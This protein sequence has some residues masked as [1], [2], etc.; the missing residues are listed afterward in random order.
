MSQPNEDR[1]KGDRRKPARR[2]VHPIIYVGLGSVLALTFCW[3]Y[4]ESNFQLVERRSV[5]QELSSGAPRRS[6]KDYDK[7]RQKVLAR[8]LE[9]RNKL[10]AKRESRRSNVGSV[11]AKQHYKDRLEKLKADLAIHDKFSDR[12]GSIG[13][14]LKQQMKNMEQDIPPD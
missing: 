7:F 2:T 14:D 3:I 12:K 13:W 6:N 1:R 10:I 9:M 5:E 11:N 8:D 4:I